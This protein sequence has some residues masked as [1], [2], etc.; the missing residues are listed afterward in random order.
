MYTRAYVALIAHIIVL[1]MTARSLVIKSG[2]N[3]RPVYIKMDH[4]REVCGLSGNKARKFQFLI[5]RLQE[6]RFPRILASVGGVQSNAMLSI[7]RLVE[8]ANQK[9]D[10]TEQPCALHYFTKP[11]PSNLL[12]SP[13]GN[14]KHA[15]GAGTKI[16]ELTADQYAQLASLPVSAT[17]SDLPAW[18][19]GGLN[20]PCS[21]G[22]DGVWIPQG[23][24]MKEAAEGLNELV[25]EI[26]ED[27]SGLQKSGDRKIN[28]WKA[29]E[30]CDTFRFSYV[31]INADNFCKRY[32][33][34]CI[35]RIKKTSSTS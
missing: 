10:W 31:A 13:T 16:H 33:H 7:A 4:Q 3:N 32:W 18:S 30:L 8:T 27:I 12:A 5:K 14:Y 34:K 20:I 6:K 24:A 1:I 23:G 35:I 2:I 22:V 21:R 28:E 17:F 19:A 26:V 25:D 15:L 29:R 9:R 11:L